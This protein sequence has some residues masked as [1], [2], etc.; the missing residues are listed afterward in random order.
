M[1]LSQSTLHPWTLT[2]SLVQG[3]F[4]RICII[5]TFTNYYAEA[6]DSSAPDV[7]SYMSGHPPLMYPLVI[8]SGMVNANASFPIL[9]IKGTGGSQPLSEDIIVVADLPSM[10]P[11]A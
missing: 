3:G 1:P 6:T 9:P 10:V 4:Q 11:K 8:W 5:A 2:T 7:L